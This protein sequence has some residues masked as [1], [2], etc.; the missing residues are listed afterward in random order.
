MAK[1]PRSKYDTQQTEIIATSLLQAALV[2]E[3]FEIAVPRRDRGIDLI[4]YSDTPNK[5]FTALPIQIKASRDSAFG[6]FRKYERFGSMIMVNVWFT[7]T[8]KPRFIIMPYQDALKF[9]PNLNGHSW[10]N[11]HCYTWTKL[12]KKVE[13]HI[14]AYENRWDLIRQTLLID[15]EC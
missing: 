8:D 13:Q 11:N 15:A 3:G 5:P 12:P 10:Q 4:I 14:L 6:V 9:V 7:L 2:R 1:E